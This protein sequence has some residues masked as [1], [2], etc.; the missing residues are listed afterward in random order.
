MNSN[1]KLKIFNI[2]NVS[3]VAFLLITI[4]L[5]IWN[6]VALSFNDA[7]DALSGGI[8]LFP[9]EFSLENYT[10]VFSDPLI[11][12]AFIISI[13]K[14]FIGVIVHVTFTGVV[15]YAVSK[16]NVFGR[17]LFIRMGV[18]TMFFSGGLIP[19]Y[20]LINNLGLINSFW[21]YIIPAMFSFY[22]LVIMM[23]FFRE[24][25]A[26]ID[27]SAR[28][29]GSNEWQIFYKIYVPLSLPVIAT[30]ALF[31]GVYQWNDYITTKLYVN[32]ASLYSIQYYL[33][34]LLTSAKA[35]TASTGGAAVQSSVTS[36][37]LELATMVISTIPIVV[38]YP[39][40][41]K[42]FVK[43]LTLGGVKE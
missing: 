26:S 8:Y 11:I 6:I 12:N 42:Y 29:D 43:G 1:N 25:P 20:L 30:I 40:L 21:V 15:A 13:M 3:L 7:Q 36:E 41:Q 16:P 22:D 9:R 28:I 33:Y 37:S 27:E 2:V 17:N 24:I 10:T 32:D 4:I 38:T 39:F 5:P 35:A 19:T 31:H 18:I 23:N 34:D 14:T